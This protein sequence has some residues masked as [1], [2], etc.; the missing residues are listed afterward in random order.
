MYHG[1]S[2]HADS[3]MTFISNP[4]TTHNT[5][6]VEDPTLP[7]DNGLRV[8]STLPSTSNYDVAAVTDDHETCSSYH[9]PSATRVYTPTW[10]ENTLKYADAENIDDDRP[11]LEHWVYKTSNS[12]IT[13]AER[14]EKSNWQADCSKL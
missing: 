7:H 8:Q 4:T 14:L 11:Q 5:T 12:E 13:I 10:T 1:A 6:A 3:M 2:E 9:T